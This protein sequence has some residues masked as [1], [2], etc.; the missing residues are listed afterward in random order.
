MKSCSSPTGFGLAHRVHPDSYIWRIS[1]IRR[2]PGACP[3]V[4]PLALRIG[5]DQGAFAAGTVKKESYS[6]AAT[7]A[8]MATSARLNTYQL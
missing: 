7:P 3:L 4:S 6:R 2:L 5:R 8:T 1:R